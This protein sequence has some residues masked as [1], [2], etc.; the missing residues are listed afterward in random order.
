MVMIIS[1]IADS[2]WEPIVRKALS[3]LFDVHYL[4]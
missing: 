3:Y 1:M 2:Y 4:I